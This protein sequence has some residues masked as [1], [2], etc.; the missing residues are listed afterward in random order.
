MRIASTS[1]FNP[2]ATGRIQEIQQLK[3]P[4]RSHLAGRAI[5]DRAIVHVHDVLAD[6]E[7]SR[8]LALAG[9][10]RAVLSV[11]LL[12]DGK[13]V[14][15]LS[16]GKSEPTLFSERQVQ[17]L[18]TFAEQALI[19]IEN[20]RLF[21]AEQQRTRELSESLDQQ[22]ATSEVL[23]VIS[24]SPG[25]LEPVFQTILS[26]ATRLCEAKFGT[27]YRYDG[28]TFYPVTFHKVPPSFADFLRQ[29]GS[30]VPPPGTPIDRLLRTRDVVRTADDSAEET[31]SPSALLAGAKSH[32]AVP[33]FKDGELTGAIVIYRMEVRPFTDKQVELVTNFAAQA[34]IAIENT[35]LLNELRE[36]LEQQTATSEVLKIISSSPSDLKP[37]FHS[38]LENSVRICEAKFGQMFLCEGDKVRAVATLDVPAALV[39]EDER[40]GA[41]QPSAEGGLVRAIRTKKVLHI[42]DLMSEQPSLPVVKLGGARSYIAVPMLKESDVVGVI[43]IYRQEVRPFTGK[44]VDLV[45]NFAASG[46]HRVID[47]NA[48]VEESLNLPWHGARAE[49]KGFEIRLK[50]SFDP[51]AGEADVFPQDIRRALLNV[52]SN[53]FYAATKRRAETDGADYEPTL[54]ASTKNLGYRVE[55]RIGD[56]GS[57][58]TPEVKEKMFI[59]FFT[60]KPTGEGTGLGLSISHDIIVKQHG[61]SIEVETRPGEFTE[62]RVIL[63]RA[64]VFV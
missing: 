40:R 12:R 10:W 29:R 60:T 11:P 30:F 43:V 59:P 13:P 15:A 1:N 14:G 4:E 31:P 58:M 49:T 20:V 35:R 50:Q 6:P 22:T 53:G 46:E 7:Y 27:L 52:I 17:L 48:L 44:Q 26:N 45:K 47:V 42:D 32:V 3:R 63:P 2:E 16:L 41:F 62:I 38:M 64:A 25:E 9:G 5:L 37:V 8:E 33:M 54:T 36:S 56:N 51:S 61:G 18:Q 19:A 28:G 34:V 24:N 55:I 21:E 39:Q 23:R 57:G